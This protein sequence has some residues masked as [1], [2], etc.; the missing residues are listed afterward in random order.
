MTKEKE[1]AVAGKYIKFLEKENKDLRKY[2]D[3]KRV[4]FN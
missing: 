1:I 4:V 3:L 2:I